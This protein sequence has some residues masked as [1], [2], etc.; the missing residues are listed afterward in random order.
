MRQGQVDCVY[1]ISSNSMLPAQQEVVSDSRKP[2]SN[3]GA[4]AGPTLECV[5]LYYRSSLPASLTDSVLP[6]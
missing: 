4:Y 1:P 6:M 2:L 5:D 3:W